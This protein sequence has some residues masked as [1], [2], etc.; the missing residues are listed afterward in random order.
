VCVLSDYFVLILKEPYFFVSTE[1]LSFTAILAILLTFE[2]LM[3]A[4]LVLAILTLLLL[5]P[6]ETLFS[7]YF[8]LSPKT[9]V[10]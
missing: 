1:L 3:I 8:L 5:V 9:G 7:F 10:L 4:L 6:V 2:L